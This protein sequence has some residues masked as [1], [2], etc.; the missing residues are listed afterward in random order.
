MRVRV[1]LRLDL[2]LGL[3]LGLGL[4][5]TLEDRVM[6]RTYYSNRQSLSLELLPVRTWETRV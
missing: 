6:G 2:G 3:T 4:G 1:G 5:L